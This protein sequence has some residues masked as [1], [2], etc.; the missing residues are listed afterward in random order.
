M[1]IDLRTLNHGPTF[2]RQTHRVTSTLHWGEFAIGMFCEAKL[3]QHMDG[4]GDAL[5]AL[6]DRHRA[7]LPRDSELA[8]G[9]VSGY[10]LKCPNAIADQAEAIVRGRHAE[11]LAFGY[12]NLAL[13]REAVQ[14]TEPDAP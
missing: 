14:A 7:A 3:R 2:D 1:S 5:R 12:D 8:T 6:F 10:W 9:G 11:Y 13:M 4:A